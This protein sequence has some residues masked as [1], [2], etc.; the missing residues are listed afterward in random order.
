MKKLNLLLP[1]LAIGFGIF[2]QPALNPAVSPKPKDSLATILYLPSKNLRDSA[3]RSQSLQKLAEQVCAQYDKNEKNQMEQ[4]ARATYYDTAIVLELAAGHYKNTLSKIDSFR[5]Y[6]NYDS[7]NRAY[8]L[9]YETYAQTMGKSGYSSSNF[10]ELYSQQFKG[11]FNTLATAREKIFADYFFD[12]T[13]IS[14]DSTNIHNSLNKQIELYADSIG[15]QSALYLSYLYGDFLVSSATTPIARQIINHSEYHLL[16]PFI[17]VQGAAVAPVQNIDALPDPNTKYKLLLEMFSGIK[18]KSDSA[19]IHSVHGGITEV[20]RKINLHLIAGVKMQDLD[21]VMIIHGP[22]MRSFYNNETYRKKY[23]ADNPNI[24]LIRQLQSAG[25][26]IVACGQSM[27]FMNVKK[28]E[29]L[30]GVQVALS[31]Q[32]ALSTYRSKNYVLYSLD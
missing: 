14:N 17:R 21:V 7:G 11:A 19:N 16:Y 25:V 3:N 32:T 5:K 4:E 23:K 6:T 8:Y 27:F 31:A 26:K 29:F 22:A 10:N 12:S 2:A 9:D 13:R 28:E 30:P 15:Y 1:A 18:N 24:T 20:G